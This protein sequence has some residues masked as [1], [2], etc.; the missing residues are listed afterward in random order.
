MRL[1]RELSNDRQLAVS[2]TAVAR[3]SPGLERF[4]IALVA[5]L[6][7]TA[8]ASVGFGVVLRACSVSKGNPFLQWQD[9]SNGRNVQRD[10]VDVL[11]GCS[12]TVEKRG[13][14]ERARTPMGS[15]ADEG[16]S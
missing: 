11:C 15:D 12:Q 10:R 9:W 8:V 3:G 2:S 13:S 7:A 5:P 14:V 4:Y 1:S 16:Y 6:F